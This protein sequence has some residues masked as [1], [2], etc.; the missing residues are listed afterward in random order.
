MESEDPI[1]EACVEDPLAEPD[2]KE[3]DVLAEL[4]GER[5]HLIVVF[6]HES[7]ATGEFD[8]GGGALD[9]EVVG[10]GVAGLDCETSLHQIVGEARLEEIAK[11]ERKA[12][13][14]RGQHEEPEEAAGGSTPHL[15]EP[16]LAR[17]EVQNAV[18]APEIEIEW[19]TGP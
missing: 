2:R 12:A 15:R 8:G 6:V 19:G 7:G 4:R 11:V 5:Q 13:R 10:V 18:Q 9:E 14:Q 3:G 17:P 16:S 1:E